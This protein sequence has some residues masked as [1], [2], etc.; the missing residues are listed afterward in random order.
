MMH[1]VAG[2]TV[3]DAR[4]GDIFSVVYIA[5]S[6]SSRKIARGREAGLDD[7]GRSRMKTVQIL[8]KANRTIYAILL[9]GKMKGKT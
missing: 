7:Q 9:R 8:I 5:V 4:I 6:E 2:R 1:G 3:D